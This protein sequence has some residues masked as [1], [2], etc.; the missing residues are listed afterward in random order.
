MTILQ[1]T[2]THVMDYDPRKERCH[3]LKG[4]EDQAKRYSFPKSKSPAEIS[5]RHWTWLNILAA[6]IF[7][8]LYIYSGSQSAIYLAICWAPTIYLVAVRAHIHITFMTVYCHS[9]ILLLLIVFNLL[10]GLI[11]KLNFVIGL[12]VQEKT[13]SMVLGTH[14][15]LATCPLWIRG[16]YY[17]CIPMHRHLFIC[18]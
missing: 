10:L 15:D 3:I 13:L 8:S 4:L 5:L 14:G 7:D 12:Y 18:T 17:I 6:L 1:T 11:Y 16:D 9:S 2:H